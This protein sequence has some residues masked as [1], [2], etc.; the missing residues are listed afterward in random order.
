MRRLRSLSR[1]P[2][3]DQAAPGN[4]Y[5]EIV[6]FGADE[7]GRATTAQSGYFLYSRAHSGVGGAN[8]GRA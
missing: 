8:T 1:T 5:S 6:L 2:G 3:P 4:L 7:Q